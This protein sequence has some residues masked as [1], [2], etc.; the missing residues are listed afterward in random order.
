MNIYSFSYIFA[1][2][3]SC[4]AMDIH[5]CQCVHVAYCKS[6][7]LFTLV[8]FSAGVVKKHIQR[9]G[10]YHKKGHPRMHKFLLVA[11]Y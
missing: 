4:N 7:L 9:D 1:H 6:E 5:Q 3:Q 10:G 2:W 8:Y 11:V